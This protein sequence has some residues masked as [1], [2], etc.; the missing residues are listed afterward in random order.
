MKRH[1]LTLAAIT[2][3]TM[4]ITAFTACKDEDNTPDEEKSAVDNGLWLV[5]P[6][7]MD[8]SVRPGDDFF[9]YCN[10]G[11]WIGNPVNEDSM[12]I[13]SMHHADVPRL[14]EQ[15]MSALHFPST[16]KMKEDADK[17]DEATVAHQDQLIMSAMERINALTTVEEAGRLLAQFMKEGYSVPFKLTPFYKGG[18]I[19]VIL[20]LDAAS[21]F[22]AQSR[23]K[24]HSVEWELAHNPEMLAKVRPLGGT[25]RSFDAEEWPLLKTIFEELGIPLEYAYT[26]ADFPGTSQAAIASQEGV[27]QV[28]QNGDMET[29]KSLLIKT[30]ANDVVLF[31]DAGLAN[32]NESQPTPLTRQDLVKNFS[33]RYLRYERG[34][35]FSE[36]YVTSDMK[37]RTREICELMRETFRQRIT[38]NEWMSEASK[39]SARDK[40]DAMVFNIGCPDEWFEEGMPD[41]SREPSLL[42]DVMSVRRTNLNLVKH[43]IG[44][45]R[46]RASFHNIIL[47]RDLTTVNA[48]YH[49]NSN[50]MNIFPVWLMEP[51]YDP[52]NN[53]A[54]NY[55]TY[56]TIGH[57][58]THGFDTTGST[59]NKIG[60]PEEIWASDADR[61]EFLR[62]AQLLIDCFNGFEVMPWALPGLYNDGPYTVGENIADLGGFILAYETYVQ[63]LRDHHFTGEE[64]DLQRQRFYLAEA[65]AWRARYSVKYTQV[66]TLGL[67][68]TTSGKDYHS[69]FR[70]RING[71]VMNTDDWYELFPIAPTDK[72]YR[73]PEDRIRIW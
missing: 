63:Y 8:T 24:K 2:C 68:G 1:L 37:Q 4:I 66:R 44:M 43:L 32:F 53:E 19:A 29:W 34:R 46:T 39:Q 49:P 33:D 70:E 48:F 10:G 67:D 69:L 56:M 7:N 13:I 64:F 73:A 45:D 40:L 47:L 11:Y 5:T 55:A 42:D 23:V 36:A 22:I 3:C 54:H 62:R 30:I 41:I 21:Q 20:E 65:W 27:I 25:T 60:D 16:E 72:L 51:Y 71:T 31:D 18:K 12:Q 52:R 57:E 58:V 15:R 26:I 50:S 6:D 59:F 38:A 9:M 28:L 17:M 14:N 61:Q 35:V